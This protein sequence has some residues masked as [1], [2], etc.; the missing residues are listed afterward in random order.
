MK[1]LRKKNLF[2]KKILR[3][4]YGKKKPKPKPKPL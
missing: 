1:I 2:K 3:I 4:I